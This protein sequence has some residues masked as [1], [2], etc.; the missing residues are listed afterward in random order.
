MDALERADEYTPQQLSRREALQR[1]AIFL[2]G[3]LAASTIAGAMAE[4]AFA[5][6]EGSGVRG[7][8]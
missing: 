4:D 5:Y 1:L 2:G 8:G 6:S 3:T 7:Q